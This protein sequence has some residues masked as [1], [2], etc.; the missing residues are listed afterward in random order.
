MGH[1]GSLE[2]TD[3]SVE[4]ILNDFTVKRNLQTM[5]DKPHLRSKVKSGGTISSKTPDPRIRHYNLMVSTKQDDHK[6]ALKK[7]MEEEGKNLD[8]SQ[9]TKEMLLNCRVVR[10]KNFN[11]VP[12]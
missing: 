10:R 6:I 12:L 5:L 11:V 4:K 2:D 3:K 9:V 1:K 7:L 8:P